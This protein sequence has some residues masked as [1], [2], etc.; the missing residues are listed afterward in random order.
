MEA[1]TNG[2]LVIRSDNERIVLSNKGASYGNM[3]LLLCDTALEAIL[4]IVQSLESV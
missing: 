3:T 1:P 2:L 4:L